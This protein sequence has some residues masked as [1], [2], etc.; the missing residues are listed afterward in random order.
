MRGGTM[1]LSA[2]AYGRFT[3]YYAMT[4]ILG[5]ALVKPGLR[6]LGPRLHTTLS[7][8]ASVTSFF[9]WSTRYV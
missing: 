4:A 9:A 8:L 5:K 3:S 2:E 6:F 7:N 1:R